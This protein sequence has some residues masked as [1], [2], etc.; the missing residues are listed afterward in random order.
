MAR[1]RNRNIQRTERSYEEFLY[2]APTLQISRTEL[3]R[4]IRGGEDTYFELKV[5]L[6]NS[7]KIAQG[8]IA[9]A[10]TDGGIFVFGVSD[11][12]RI[13]GL[14][15]PEE[16][17][18]ELVRICREEIYPP[19]VPLLDM[20]S[21]DN[22][23]RI[24]ALEVVG[25]KK[26]Y[27]TKDGRFFMRFGAEK[28]EASREE[29]S[30]WLDEIRPLNYENIPV[31]GAT[32]TDIDDALLWSF[33]KKFEDD[34]DSKFTWETGEFLRKDLL[35][36]V[37]TIEEITPTVAA[38]L[39]FGK[40]ERVPELLP[41][42]TVYA[43]RFS[44]E[45]GQSQVVETVEIKGNLVT[46]YEQSLRFI[47]RW[48]DLL[49]EKQKKAASSNSPIVSRQSYQENVVCEMVVNALVHRDMALRDNKTRL[50]IFDNA[51]EIIN[52]RRTNGFVP[53]ASR[54]IRYGITQRLNPQIAS[55]F[56]SPAY[57]ANRFSSSLPQLLKDAR[58]FSDKRAEIQTNNDEFRLKIFGR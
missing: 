48:C 47:K 24:I 56:H 5:K 53:P 10:N 6:S 29:L 27:R 42:S 11:Q 13:E 45:N 7:E 55:I 20:M 50:H 38:I 8:I 18:T 49:A 26:P 34:I 30:S 4:M 16:V 1:R 17:R 35:L 51:I 9:L 36:A 46:I 12:L 43:T 41:R 58:N 14:E 32:E 57:E 33:A 15:N 52:P 2:N 28:R 39:L 22:G 40:N 25:N 37:G 21:F 3:I 54:A 19:L 44:G 31:V 23:R